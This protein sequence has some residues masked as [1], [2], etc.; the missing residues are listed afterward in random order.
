MTQAA[1]NNNLQPLK[2][3]PDLSEVP[4][5]LPAVRAADVKS[6]LPRFVIF[7]Y[8]IDYNVNIIGGEAGTGKTWALCGWMAALSKS[9]P[10]AMAGIVKKHGNVVYLGSEDGNG[11]M[12]HRLETMDADMNRIFLVEEHNFDVMSPTFKGL[13]DRYRP[14]LIIVDALMSYWPADLNPNN[15]IH[16][17][18]VMD[19]LRDVARSYG[20]CI[21]CVIHPSKKEDYRL[22]HRFAGSGAFVDSVRSALYVGYHPEEPAKRVIVQVKHNSTSYYLPALF[23]LDT[24]NGF[25]WRGSDEEL[26][27][28]DIEKALR[29]ELTRGKNENPLFVEII[30][31]ALQKYPAGLD[32]SAKDII[33]IFNKDHQHEI[34]TMSF[35]RALSN[36]VKDKTMLP[37]EIIIEKSSSTGNRQRYKI[38]YKESVMQLE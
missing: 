18:R 29:K 6:E 16:C 22:V 20:T 36:M 5:N 9:K 21:L 30:K 13:I 14:K 2:V 17:R 7:P 28:T 38:Y 25:T 10:R 15:Q 32:A 1:E 26:T 33:E 12:K 34:N 3:D 24:E 4:A 37:D 8:L 27:V 35:G 11:A 19:Y 23:E 31:D